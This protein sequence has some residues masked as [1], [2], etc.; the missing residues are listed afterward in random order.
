VYRIDDDRRLVRV[1]SVDHRSD[2]YRRR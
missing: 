1:E 2:V